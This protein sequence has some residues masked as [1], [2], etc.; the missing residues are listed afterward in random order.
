MAKGADSIGDHARSPT[1]ANSQRRRRTVRLVAALVP[2]GAIQ[3]ERW[4]HLDSWNKVHAVRVRDIKP[5]DTGLFTRLDANPFT[6]AVARREFAATE[7]AT[8][9]QR[10]DAAQCR[11]QHAPP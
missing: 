3:L 10:N 2:N 11:P 6:A 5:V 8:A 1:V 4:H 9:H 7:R